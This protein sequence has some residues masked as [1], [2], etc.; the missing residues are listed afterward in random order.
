VRRPDTN[1]AGNVPISVRSHPAEKQQVPQELHKFLLL[2]PTL[3]PTSVC[4]TQHHRAPVQRIV[5]IKYGNL[6]LYLSSRLTY[7]IILLTTWQWVRMFHYVHINAIIYRHFG[8]TLMSG[9]PA[10]LKYTK[11][12]SRW[13]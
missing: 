7:K 4:V 5:H 6:I 1:Q 10:Y 12:L 11:T 8:Q 3:H 9:F 2:Y 13:R